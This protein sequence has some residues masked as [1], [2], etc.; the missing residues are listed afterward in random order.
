MKIKAVLFSLLALAAVVA[1]AAPIQV[2]LTGYTS[3]SLDGDIFPARG[4]VLT[5]KGDTTA[6]TEMDPNVWILSVTASIWVN[7]Y[8]DLGVLSP[9]Q[10][11]YNYLGDSLGLTVLDSGSFGSDLIAA[12]SAGLSSW[13]LLSS[14]ATTY[15]D[16]SFFANGPDTF[17][18]SGGYLQLNDFVSDG[19]YTIKVG[20]AATVPEGGSLLLVVGASLAILARF[21]PRR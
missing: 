6:W 9:V 12:D 10:I 19:S 15:T 3:G 18:T 17:L 1:Q 13:D 14:V 16:I 5:A 11:Y 8:G 20:R 4:I 2:T 21:R 7:G